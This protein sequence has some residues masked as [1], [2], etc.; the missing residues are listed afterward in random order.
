MF[1]QMALFRSYTCLSGI[2]LYVFHIFFIY[3]YVSGHLGCLHILAIINSAPT[4]IRM[5]VS[6]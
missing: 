3:S 6:F 1:L 4:N 5:H 2:P